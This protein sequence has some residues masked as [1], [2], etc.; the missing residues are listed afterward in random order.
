MHKLKQVLNFPCPFIYNSLA[1]IVLVCFVINAFVLIVKPS[2][3]YNE[4]DANLI[5]IGFGVISL[6]GFLLT[7]GLTRILKPGFLDDENWTIKKQ[8]IHYIVIVCVI[9]VPSFYYAVIINF[10]DNNWS[11]FWFIYVR[12]IIPPLIPVIAFALAKHHIDLTKNLKE[13]L[14][15]SNSLS[16]SSFNTS[17]VLK[18][19]EL[20]IGKFKCN[21]DK[22]LYFESDNN[23][24]N[25]VCLQNGKAIQKQVRITL[26]NVEEQIIDNS[27][28]MRVHRAFIINLNY[29][30][31][32]SGNAQG[33]KV[34]L[35]HATDKISVSRSYINDFRKQVKSFQD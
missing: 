7:V 29:V 4:N 31:G 32:V 11:G 14:E 25:I 34:K 20:L 27:S 8:L 18:E 13:A 30:K 28:F 15:I 2:W 17:S 22:V 3:F 5:I 33:L 19:N 16:G 12:S 21:A 6:I 10:V 35:D 23:C 9:S 26:K 1:E 24:V